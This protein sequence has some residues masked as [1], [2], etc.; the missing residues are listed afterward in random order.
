MEGQR[1]MDLVR[2]GDAAKVLGSQGQNIE[3]IDLNFQLIKDPASNPNYGFKAGRNELLPF[4]K[5]EIDQ[6]PNITQNPG[7]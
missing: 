2:W 4:P 7:Y 3:T 6:N 5:K 1:F